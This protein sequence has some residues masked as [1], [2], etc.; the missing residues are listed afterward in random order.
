[1]FLSNVSE[2]EIESIGWK[3]KRMG[4]QPLNADGTPMDFANP[5]RPVFIERGKIE[6]A[7]ESSDNGKNTE[8]LKRLL[9]EN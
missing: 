5:L 6:E 1:M 3:S 4:K 7:I 8:T 9:Q 2:N